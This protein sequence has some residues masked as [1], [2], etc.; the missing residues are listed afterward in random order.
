MK[1]MVTWTLREN[2]IERAAK[3]F[4]SGEAQ[5]PEG[6]TLVGRW[7]AADLSCGWALH[8]SDDAQAIFGLSVK[9]AEDLGLQI[10]P[11]IEDEAAG[12]ELSKRY[13]GA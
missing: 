11:V 1:F 2:S 8:E 12:A 13:G 9:W 10:V 5:P 3:R 7:H 6:V 4:L